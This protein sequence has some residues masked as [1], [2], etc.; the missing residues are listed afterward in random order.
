MIVIIASLNRPTNGNSNNCQ[1]EGNGEIC[2]KYRIG[3]GELLR[4]VSRHVLHW[5]ILE[6]Q[7]PEGPTYWTDQVS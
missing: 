6:I 1:N 4:Q 2:W 5:E 7:I 3:K